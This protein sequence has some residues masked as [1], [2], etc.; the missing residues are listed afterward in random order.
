MAD[1]KSLTKIADKWSSNS[2]ASEARASYAD[3]VANPRRS[4]AASAAAA[5]QARKDGLADADARNAFVN[6]VNDAGD[7]KWKNRATT[8]GPSR[9]STGV[10]AAKP[11]YSAGFAP[12]HSVIANTTLPPRG[13]KGSPENFERVR[14]IGD[15]L[16]AAKIA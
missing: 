2:S 10:Q 8:L 11:D 1:I 9:F 3:G 7:A 15:A 4:W 6:G 13:P 16:H 14:V 5:D 12:Y